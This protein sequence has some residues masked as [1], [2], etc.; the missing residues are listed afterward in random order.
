MRKIPK[1][2]QKIIDDLR[3]VSTATLTVILYRLTGS[4][5]PYFMEHLKPMSG[6]LKPG[7]NLVGRARTI[8]YEEIP[9]VTRDLMVFKRAD[10][11]VWETLEKG[12]VI[13]NATLGRTEWGHYGDL[14]CFL[15]MGKGATGLI[16]DGVL[17]DTPY[18]QETKWPVFTLEGG[19]NPAART[20]RS[21]PTIIIPRY[22]DVDVK[23]DGCTVRPGDIIV[24]DGEGVLVIPIELAEEVAKRGLAM[25]KIEKLCREKILEGVWAHPLSRK[26]IEEAG[27]MKEAE[28][29]GYIEIYPELNRR[30]NGEA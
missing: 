21:T 10:D 8:Q 11:L 25:E 6:D 20:T 14:F 30:G 17:R 26:I 3:Q 12:D 5:D 19:S 2:S 9:K 1:P 16:T 13:V 23:C 4:C 22:A 27:L 29:S 7:N 28:I 24:G 18:I 15:F